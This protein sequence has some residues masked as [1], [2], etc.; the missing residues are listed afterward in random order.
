M[1]TMKR[2]KV[3][4]YLN[5]PDDLKNAC[6]VY[7]NTM[8]MRHCGGVK[9]RFVNKVET[10]I[11]F[12]P[13]ARK[14]TGIRLEAGD[15]EW[16]DVV[17]FSRHYDQF[18]LMGCLAEVAKKMGK[19]IVYE[20]DDLLHRIEVN[21]GKHKRDGDG[22]VK[23]LRFI[24]SVSKMID[25]V[26]VSTDYLGDFYREK[27]GAPTFVLPNCYDPFDWLFLNLY[28]KLR[29]F[30]RRRVIGDR[31][32][33]IGWQGGNNHFLNNF[34][35]IVDP[36]NAIKKKYGDRVQFVAMAGQH[37][38]VDVYGGE[39]EKRK[40]L[41]FNF[42]YRQPV[43]VDRFPRA[44]ASM[45][46]DIGLIVVEDNEFSRA[47]SNI[48]WMEYALL[49]IPAVSSDCEPYRSTNAVL[50]DNSF[51]AWVSAISSMVESAEK[52]ATIGSEARRMVK[53]LSIRR[54]AR[55]WLEVYRWALRG[56]ANG[57]VDVTSKKDKQQC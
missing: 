8:P 13:L 33:R 25:V 23:Q 26:T 29:M 52:R 41:D 46:I 9:V 36:L 38:N 44:L 21:L 5:H 48:K 42:E 35:Y 57:K 34:N 3:L 43:K 10:Q 56:G 15:I 55:R 47:K 2:I 19:V 31:T 4:M 11:D 18:E 28:R 14:V 12:N 50:V 49:G 7:R 51:D 32:I 30:W 22:I 24:D 20:T 40:F 54:H 6:T 39:K 1:F 53:S 17:V 37:P 16:A 27:Y 45:D